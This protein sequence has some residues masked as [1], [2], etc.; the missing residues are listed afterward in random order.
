MYRWKACWV[1]VNVSARCWLFFRRHIFGS[2]EISFVSIRNYPFMFF[3][4][5]PAPAPFPIACH[6]VST[7][8]GRPLTITQEN[9]LISWTYGRFA[10]VVARVALELTRQ[11]RA[12]VLLSLCAFSS[13][14]PVVRSTLRYTH[15]Y[16]YSPLTR[17][18]P[19]HTLSLCGSLA[20]PRTSPL[21]NPGFLGRSSGPQRSSFG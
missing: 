13:S 6:G 19:L 14:M 16:I 3:S 4:R 1:R 12:F 8:A 15:A 21:C 17:P 20:I 7:A 18:S 5:S 9:S 2:S 10:A 11:A